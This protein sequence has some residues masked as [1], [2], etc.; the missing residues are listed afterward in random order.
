MPDIKTFSLVDFDGRF[1]ATHNNPFTMLDVSL[2]SRLLV[3]HII[4]TC[5]LL[6]NF[7]FSA[8]QRLFSILSLGI[9]QFTARFLKWLCHI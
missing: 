2:K 9:P 6:S 5:L 7:S 1:D 8:R 4:T 3:P